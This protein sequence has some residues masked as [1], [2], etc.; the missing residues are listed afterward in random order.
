MPV[1]G[2]QPQGVTTTASTTACTRRPARTRADHG[3]CSSSHCATAVVAAAPAAPAQAAAPPRPAAGAAPRRPTPAA[4]RAR[5]PSA[6]SPRSAPTPRRSP[7]GTTTSAAF[8][9]AEPGSRVHGQLTPPGLHPADLAA[10]YALP[11]ATRG[12]GQTVY[13]VDAYNYPNAEADLAVYRGA[14]RP[15]RLHDRQRLLPQGQPE[16][17]AP[18]RCRPPTTAGPPRWRSTWTWSRRSAPT[19]TSPWSRPT[20]PATAC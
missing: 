15:A 12:Y 18:A 6:A 11:S 20:T 3:R 9:A 2:R 19:A 10:A 16:R 17:R 5:R 4:R 8:K 1:P 14:V 13:I 7:R